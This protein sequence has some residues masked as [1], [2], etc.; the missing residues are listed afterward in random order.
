MKRILVF[1]VVLSY[2][3]YVVKIYNL[4]RVEVLGV[5]NDKEAFLSWRS[6][7]VRNYMGFCMVIFNK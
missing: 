3:A 7:E 5:V 2:S 1:L 4:E 6:K